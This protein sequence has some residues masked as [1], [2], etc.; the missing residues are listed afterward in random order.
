MNIKLVIEYNGINFNG[1][2]KQKTKLNIQGRIEKAIFD[3]TGK[4]VDLI[5]AGRTDANV[6]A[7]RSSCK[8]SY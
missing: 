1:W 5:G 7:L 4:K 2:Q 8:F 3:I 6:H